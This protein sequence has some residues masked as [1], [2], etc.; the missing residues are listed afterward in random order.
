MLKAAGLKSSTGEAQAQAVFESLKE[1]NLL[2][3]VGSMCADTTSS[4][5]GKN[6]GAAVLLRKK[7]NKNLLY[8]GCRHHVLELLPAAIHEILFE[9]ST[10][11]DIIL[12]KNFQ[13]AWENLETNIFDDCSSDKIISKYMNK[14]ERSTI[15]LFIQDQLEKYHARCDYLELLQ[16]SLIFLGGT[17]RK[18]LTIKSPGAYHRAR[19]MAKLIYALKI[20]LFRK[21]FSLSALELLALQK[22]NSFTV[23]IYIKY[24]YTCHS[25]VSAPLNDIQLLKDL[26]KF[27]KKIPEISEAT[28]SKFLDHPWYLSENV[29]GLAFF[30]N[31]IS[32]SQKRLMVA[33]LNKGSKEN[34]PMKIHFDR[35]KIKHMQI[36][37]FITKNSMQLFYLHKIPT[38]FLTKDPQLWDTDPEFITAREI[39]SKLRV[40]NDVAE[41]GVA[42]VQK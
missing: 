23:L 15:I 25:A 37:Q 3:H 14:S 20:Y 26:L 19:W 40:V 11:P 13:T 34:P 24:W 17:A 39:C 29:V 41:R 6:I 2:E 16:L 32:I 35:S 27:E 22:L 10:G 36:E 21:Q 33:A 1:W 18:K 7:I 9:K 5:T 12:F 42:L 8:F 30:D 31:R 28:I 38:S 4:N